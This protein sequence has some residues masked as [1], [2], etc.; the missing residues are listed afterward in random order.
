MNEL[1]RLEAGVAT[2]IV[3]MDENGTEKTF[4]LAILSKPDYLGGKLYEFA[5]INDDGGKIYAASI[6]GGGI[7]G[8][9]VNLNNIPPL[10]EDIS[11]VTTDLDMIKKMANEASDEEERKAIAFIVRKQKAIEQLNTLPQ[12]FFQCE[13]RGIAYTIKHNGFEF[14][15]GYSNDRDAYRGGYSVYRGKKEPKR[16]IDF[17]RSIFLYPYFRKDG[18]M[19]KKK[20]SEKSEYFVG[21]TGLSN[22]AISLVKLL[23]IKLDEARKQVMDII[24][25]AHYGG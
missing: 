7:T 25:A 21:Y 9:G 16:S 17:D 13:V 6:Y 15:S 5:Y 24:N 10:H 12:V 19:L 8:T 18:V 1:R 20:V 23:K 22:E 2:K 4:K 14:L 11:V 3:V